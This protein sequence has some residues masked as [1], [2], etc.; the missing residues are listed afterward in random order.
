MLGRW[1]LA[2]LRIRVWLRP[3]SSRYRASFFSSIC[4]FSSS[5]FFRFFSIEEI[6]KR[7]EDTKTER[8]LGIAALELQGTF[9]SPTATFLPHQ[10][11]EAADGHSFFS[12]VQHWTG[13]LLLQPVFL[14]TL[15]NVTLNVISAS[16][17]FTWLCRFIMSA[18]ISELDSLNS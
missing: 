14:P 10:R 18:S 5:M 2:K 1:M 3:E 7:L 4:L 8:C 16:A 12:A 17:S 15:L 13:I 9:V 6:C 11:L